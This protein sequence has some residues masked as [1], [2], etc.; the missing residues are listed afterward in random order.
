MTT[1]LPVES[2]VW[3]NTLCFTIIVHIQLI[4]MAYSP[5]LG[6][7]ALR[8]L[9]CRLTCTLLLIKILVKFW[10][11]VSGIIQKY[12]IPDRTIGVLNMLYYVCNAQRY[13]QKS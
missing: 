8:L 11:D 13:L 10:S 6:G 5:C 9:T 7:S 3:Y 1:V 4:Q 12:G 2:A